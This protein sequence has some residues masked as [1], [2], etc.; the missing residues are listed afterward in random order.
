L[1]LLILAGCSSSS[2]YFQN[3]QYDTAINKAVKKIRKKPASKKD[4]DVL[5]NEQ[6]VV[7]LYSR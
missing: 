1:S 4:I 6:V 3:G 2:K 5:V 7:E